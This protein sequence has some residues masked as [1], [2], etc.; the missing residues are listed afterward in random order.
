MYLFNLFQSILL[1]LFN[2]DLITVDLLIGEYDI[3]KG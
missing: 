3:Y 2:E 1:G